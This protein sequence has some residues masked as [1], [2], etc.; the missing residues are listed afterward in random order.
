LLFQN[1]SESGI[2]SF[3]ITKRSKIW[4]AFQQKLWD[5]AAMTDMEGVGE[6]GEVLGNT[7]DIL[8]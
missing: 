6:E 8:R 4:T 2:K 1:A 7:F 3:C 5:F